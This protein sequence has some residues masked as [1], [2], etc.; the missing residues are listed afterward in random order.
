MSTIID[1][2]K[3]K[4]KNGNLLIKVI[5]VNVGVY[6]V[7]LLLNIISPLIS[8]NQNFSI[9]N[10]YLFPFLALHSNL[11]EL[12]FKPWTIITHMFV[13]DLGI[14]HLFWNMMLLYLAGD[15]FLNYFS[16]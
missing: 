7:F 8:G 13:H 4:Y 6:L 2:I 5:F 9:V 3:Q 1:D 11:L 16:H 15:Q 10:E 14:S 12:L